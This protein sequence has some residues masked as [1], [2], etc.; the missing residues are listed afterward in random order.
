MINL[1]PNIAKKKLVVEYWTRVVSVWLLL[2]SVALVV[3]ALILFPVQ[4]LIEGQISVQEASATE[5]YQKVA[6]YE[7]VSSDL[8][9]TSLQASWIIKESRLHSFSSLISLFGSLQGEGVYINE[10]QLGREQGGMSPV[11]LLGQSDSRHQLAS[12]RERLLSDL[13]IESVDLPISNLAQ[14]KDITFT[15]TVVLK[16]QENI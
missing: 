9:N 3:S 10:I 15:I 7:N 2:W 1:I 12:F 6:G 4:V 16:K 13:L 5:A 14:D 11:V 8:A